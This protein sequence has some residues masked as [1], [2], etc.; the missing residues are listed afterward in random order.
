MQHQHR[1]YAA[2][3]FRAGDQVGPC[4]PAQFDTTHES[5]RPVVS[6]DQTLVVL[7]QERQVDLVGVERAGD[8][9]PVS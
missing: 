7:E 3:M 4:L 9:V 5:P 6:S 2:P 1:Q 8:G